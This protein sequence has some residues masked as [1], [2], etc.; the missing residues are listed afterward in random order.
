MPALRP[1]S[2]KGR[3]ASG[4][5]LFN[6]QEELNLLRQRLTRDR[7]VSEAAQAEMIATMQVAMAAAREKLTEERNAARRQSAFL[8]RCRVE[9]D[10]ARSAF[11]AD[12]KR[13]QAFFDASEAQ[14]LR[15]EKDKERAAEETARRHFE[16]GEETFGGGGSSSR[17][18]PAPLLIATPAQEKAYIAWEHAFAAFENADA[19]AASHTMD[20]LPWPP[21]TCPVS[22][23]RRGEAAEIRKQRLKLAL[24]RCTHHRPRALQ[25]LRTA[26]SARPLRA[27]TL[28]P[29]FHPP[30]P[31]VRVFATSQGIRTSLLRH[32]RASSVRMSTR[33]FVSMRLEF[34]VE[35]S[36]SA[37][38]STTKRPS[39]VAH[40]R[41]PP[42][43]PRPPLRKLPLRKQ[44]KQPPHVYRRRRNS[45]RGTTAM[46][47][48]IPGTP[49]RLAR[50]PL[51][52]GHAGL[53][54]REQRARVFARSRLL[55]LG[56][57][58]KS[59]GPRSASLL[60]T[61]P[62]A[63]L[64]RGRRSTCTSPGSRSIQNLV[65]VKVAKRHSS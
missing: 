60:L 9:A 11:E 55:H 61:R 18:L 30:S 28:W 50:H 17:S 19:N 44:P 57:N 20:T 8:R 7:E 26:A 14:R 39:K 5:P 32:I 37:R 47:A 36:T 13:R 42:L 65:K 24:L 35:S 38:L 49:D 23:S 12:V 54:T 2:A 10:A 45:I 46:G 21:T 29:L 43:G 4:R 27:I 34:S 3:D 15:R 1:S 25:C 40:P 62:P 58:P 41:P 59:H 52:R 33:P 48:S 51:A 53:P 16:Y 56:P 6:V 64:G 31:A 22:G 63:S